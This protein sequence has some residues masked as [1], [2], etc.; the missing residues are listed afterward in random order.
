MRFI[1]YMLLISILTLNTFSQEIELG[2]SEPFY[3]DA[4]VSKGKVADSA[5]I[6]VFVLVP[7]ESLMFNNNNQIYGAKYNLVLSVFDDK[8]R[9]VFTEKR[10]ETIVTKD[11]FKSQGRDADFKASQILFNLPAGNYNMKMVLRDEV[12]KNEK[13]KSRN[14]TVLDFAAFPFSL[15][16]IM[17]VS[18]I[19]ERNGKFAA[20]PHVS[21]DIGGLTDGFFAFFEVYNEKGITSVD[22]EYEITD[23]TDHL[24]FSSEKITKPLDGNR[25]QQYIKIPRLKDM[26]TGKY[27]LTLKA[28]SGDEI[29]AAAKRSIKF[30]QTI[31]GMVLKDID[32]SIR[33]L[34]YVASS[35]EQEMMENAADASTK[36]K[37]FMEFWQKLDPTPATERNEAFQQYYS[38]IAFA[39]R[40]FKSH[41]EGWLSDMGMIYVVYGTPRN[42]ERGS[43]YGDSNIYE[44]WTY[45]N[46]R[47]FVFVDNSGMND[48]RL[49]SPM[50]VTEKY[51][52]EE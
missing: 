22:F 25:S 51:K 37:L 36:Q 32:E 52:Y 35:E 19:E 31:G 26:V 15:S 43:R 49:V 6:D 9:K 44:V 4:I 47:Q 30:S 2:N 21:D 8:G 24:L 38:R 18:S 7:Y 27:T 1:L 50:G 39:N 41:R 40:K 42:A 34:K 45:K 20:T 28:K 17:I 12:N 33:Q 5:R 14:M 16:G 11:Y 3:F 48:F 10:D 13:E 23:E 46:N 29:L